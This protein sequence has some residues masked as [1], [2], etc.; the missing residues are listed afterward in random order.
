MPKI[1]KRMQ[2]FKFR[3]ELNLEEISMREKVVDYFANV[4]DKAQVA[5]DKAQKWVNG[6]ALAFAINAFGFVGHQE[7]LEQTGQ[8]LGMFETDV[9]KFFTVGMVLSGI[10]AGISIWNLNKKEA[11]LDRAMDKEDR[12]IDSLNSAIEEGDNIQ[13][14]IVRTEKFEA[15]TRWGDELAEQARQEKML[16]TSASDNAQA[17]ASVQIIKVVKPQTVVEDN[18]VSFDPTN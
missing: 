5:V 16:G 2:E 9:S 18:S 14:D 6:T 10:A 13:E 11:K 3:K 4:V 17:D 15:I 7:W 1:S 12:A 8:Y